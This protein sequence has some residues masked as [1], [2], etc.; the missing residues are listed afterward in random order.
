MKRLVLR[1]FFAAALAALV[2]PAHA[3]TG[4]LLCRLS[5]DD[6]GRDGLNLLR[7]SVGSDAVVRATPAVPV[8][9]T[10]EIAAA[11]D[12]GILAG[13]PDGDGAVAIP[14]GQHL[15]VPIPAPLVTG[16]GRPFTVVMKIRVPSAAAWRCLLNMPSANDSDAMV[17]LDRDSRKV[18]LKQSDKGNGNA[19][20]SSAAVPADS[21][22]TL[23]VAFGGSTTDVYLDGS[24][25]Y[26]G[27]SRLA[28]S[29]ADCS[30]AGGFFLVGADDNGDDGLFYLSEFRVYEGAVGPAGVL[31]GSGTRADP[32]LVA[33]VADWATFAANVNAD[34][35]ARACYLLAADVG[36]AA[37]PATAVAGVSGHP[38]RG[39]F[40]GGGHALAVAIEGAAAGLAPFGS[41][42]GATLRNLV[43]TG[44]VDS[45]GI[46]ASGLVGACGTNAPNVIADC[47][48]A[49][50]VDVH[51]AGYAGGFVGH[52]GDG[53]IVFRNC[54][55]GGTVSG[56]SVLAGGLLGW[57]ANRKLAFENCLFKGSFAPS[58]SGRFHPVALRYEVVDVAATVR[59]CY[60]PNDLSATAPAGNA[61][62]GAE[63]TPASPTAVP[64]SW[65]VPFTAPDGDTWYRAAFAGADLPYAYGFETP[66]TQD[67]WT[68][69][70]ATNSGYVLVSA[71]IEDHA[72]VFMHNGDPSLVQSLV[73]PEFRD[74]SEKT[75][76][77]R[78]MTWSINGTN[79]PAVAQLGVSSTTPD[80]SAFTWSPE[81]TF[82]SP[83]WNTARFH[84]PAGAKYVAIRWL[85]KGY[86]LF[87]DDF[88]FEAVPSFVLADDADN[89]PAIREAAGGTVNGTLRDRTFFRDGGWVPVCLPFE[90]P[91]LDGTGLQEAEV[92]TLESASLADGTLTL[93]FGPAATSIEA[94]RPYLAKWPGAVVL[95]SVDDWNEFA[96]AV[97]GGT[98]FA[99][100]TVMLQG[101][102]G[103]Q[104][105]PV[106]TMVGTEEHPFR[107]KFDGEGW[108][109]FANLGVSDGVGIPATALFRYI[110][111]ATIQNMEMSG[112]VR[113][114]DA[115]AA[116]VGVASGGTNLVRNCLFDMTLSGYGNRL[117]GIVG[118]GASS[119]TTIRDCRFAA[120]CFDAKSTAY[121]GALC[122]WVDAGGALVAE[123]CLV[124]GPDY[125][126]GSGTTADLLVSGGGTV[127]ARNC[128]KCDGCVR[129]SQATEGSWMTNAEL[130]AALGGQ[131]L[132]QEGLYLIVDLY[133]EP[134]VIFPNL[135]NPEFPFA[136][137]DDAARDV[138]TPLVDFVGNTSPV[139]LDGGDRSVLLLDPDGVLAWPDGDAVLGSCRSFFRLNGIR[140]GAEAKRYV[141]HFGGETVSGTFP[142][143][144]SLPGSGTAADP[145]VIASAADWE[146][147]AANVNAGV[148]P[149]ACYRMVADVGTAANPVTAMAGT[150]RHPFRGVFDGG[151]HALRVD[152]AAGAGDLGAAP[153]R[154]I[155]GATI[156]NL[157]VEGRVAAS[158]AFCQ[159]AGLAALCFG[160]GPNV[161]RDC[162]VS[163][164]ISGAGWAGGV[165]GYAEGDLLL[166]GCVFGG[167]LRDFGQCAGGLLGR[168]GAVALTATNCLVKGE[169]LPGQGG[170][171]HPVACKAPGAAATAAFDAVWWL[172][173]LAPTAVSPHL[174]PESNDAPVSETQT[175]EFAHPVTAAD[176]NVYYKRVT[177]W[178]LT[179]E[180]GDVRLRNGDIV[181]GTGGTNTHLVVVGGATVTL[182]GV[183]VAA[184]PDDDGHRWAG[185]TCEGNAVL[186]LEAGTTN[187]VRAGHPSCPGIYVPAG[188]TLVVRGDGV[189]DAAGGAAGAGIGGGSGLD[190]GNVSVL[191][192]TVVATGG[193][194]AAGIGGGANAACGDI[195]LGDGVV[196]VE[197][198]G[199]EGAPNGVGSG[200]GGTCGAVTVGGTETGDIALGHYV[201]DPSVGASTVRYDANGGTGSMPDQ[202][203]LPGVPRRLATNEFACV[204]WKHFDGWNTEAGGGGASYRDG[205][206]VLVAG[207]MTLYAQWKV[208]NGVLTPETEY[209]LLEDGDVLTG[210]GGTNTHVV[211]AAN[212]TVTFRN[213]AITNIPPDRDH[214]W[215]GV[216]CLGNAVV[217]LEGTNYL[218]GGYMKPG[219]QVA[220]ERSIWIQGEGSLTA[221]GG[222]GSA[223]IGARLNHSSTID[224][225]G[226]VI[227]ATGGRN[228]SGIGASFNGACGMLYIRS[229]I[230]NA[231]GGAN[232]SGIGMGNKGRYQIEIEA[233]VT[234]VTA[235]RGGT[236]GTQAIDGS[237]SDHDHWLLVHDSLYDDHGGLIRTILNPHIVPD[238]G[239]YV[240]GTVVLDDETEFV[241]LADGAVLTGEGGWQTHIE[242]AAGATVT[243]Q[244]VSV[245]SSSGWTR[246]PGI[247]CLGDAR[248]VLRGSNVVEGSIY[249]PGISVPEG[250]TLVISG[251]GELT[252]VGEVNAAGIGGGDASYCNPF[253]AAA[254][255]IV[256][257]SGT[258]TALGSYSAAA[259]GSGDYGS[260][261]DIT[262]LGGNVTA[263]AERSAAAI[264]S[265]IE[266][267]CGDISILGGNVTAVAGE[268]GP[269]IGSG[270][271][272]TCGTVSVGEGVYRVAAT[273]GSYCEN[274]IGAGWET[275]VG[276][277]VVVADGLRDVTEG[278]TR[279][280]SPV[281]VAYADWA[282]TNGV[283]GTWDA[284]DGLGVANVF[285]YVFERPEGAF[286]KTLLSISFDESGRAAV[287]HTPPRSRTATGFD[288]T[289]EAVEDLSDW[290][291]SGAGQSYPV[292][293]YGN[294]RVPA[295]LPVRFFRLKAAE[296]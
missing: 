63:G 72:F 150:V 280:L 5:F 162:T 160:D 153:F 136:E 104:E 238:P 159:P 246:W 205:Q 250:S 123:N 147:F 112:T 212:A 239:D 221:L 266:G 255:N 180:T 277:S 28:G 197:A 46:H 66:M 6:A 45:T 234:R 210:T 289:I 247:T 168:G 76:S 129:A 27:T 204:E 215:G 254:G 166:G 3:A 20:L 113:G 294:T 152:L 167:T 10:G 176:G 127:S 40:D 96:A 138:A 97:A 240:S 9:G 216:T 227:N 284:K 171:F 292:D 249:C 67:G 16:A 51:G 181:T 279:I 116:L 179:P 276:V 53:E 295:D 64:G 7:A 15:A 56:F 114:G 29:Y 209:V 18:C 119:H 235:T 43:V 220:D 121:A 296:Q 13:L 275:T 131:W 193:A 184:L 41:I 68:P 187:V 194:G 107:G 79:L 269:G 265:G 245:T 213:A 89:A 165:A 71:L 137:V 285:R 270:R 100:R 12:A 106:T 262:I 146:R 69:H 195:V 214:E 84:C 35:D 85:G 26:S 230:V 47:V 105:N 228:G 30:R 92:R 33:S 271:R 102:I 225:R 217:N 169:I 108:P 65:D 231:T 87:V 50:D 111:G 88:S 272:A 291:G 95:R 206:L 8:P 135:A 59:G 39:T 203:F 258:V 32:F 199:G 115:S 286:G 14:T 93:D 103:T 226:G 252:A 189:L 274:A 201:Y 257:E 91:F 139:G 161:L 154:C 34:A 49:T 98:T 74:L 173:G 125:R 281:P 62:P 223:G 155:A 158:G 52:G 207:D 142:A 143:L 61:V 86:V 273:P 287:I 211:I 81:T 94:G 259:I 2:L 82:E 191:G 232:A 101:P 54:V 17:Y 36:S 200:A 31:P 222:Q 55:Y 202:V 282:A 253:F 118:S 256:I 11:A 144:E 57:G 242:I 260:C 190:C 175:A 23:A 237:S 78:Y 70:C 264:G 219:L 42:D 148:D 99:G 185:I 229:G 133:H 178:T 196:R 25:I 263:V 186:V 267:R 75:M 182:A 151:G 174:F 224:I 126:Y 83:Y 80:L 241:A 58:G 192:G 38:F 130:A 110:D 22:T 198:D 278:R 141:L 37:D 117:G 293:V 90:L 134:G 19:L 164:E 170:T 172:S 268:Y 156:G 288:V 233:G 188:S 73:S 145:F 183:T 44:S 244:D 128:Y 1:P 208:N 140:A 21:W 122:G 109:I 290:T 60:Y 124:E 4:D 120:R 261:G 77:F 251:D 157:R 24:N 236:S 218:A 248:L 177:V 163:A 283:D 132:L 149:F 48:V 243:L